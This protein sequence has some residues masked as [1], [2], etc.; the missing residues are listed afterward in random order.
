MADQIARGLVETVGNHSQELEKV[1]ENLA[2][3]AK[4]QKEAIYVIELETWG[5]NGT[6]L[7]N[8]DGLRNAIEWAK[9]NGYNR[10]VVPSKEY[11]YYTITPGS[12]LKAGQAEPTLTIPSFMTIDLNGNTIKIETNSQTT[13]SIIEF[14]KGAKHSVIMNGILEGD[15]E[16]HVYAIKSGTH[17]FGHGVVYR[18]SNFCKL[19]NLEIKN[20]TGDGVYFGSFRTF[21]W[22]DKLTSSNFELG[23]FDETGVKIDSSTTIR[24]INKVLLDDA[25]WENINYLCPEI[26]FEGNYTSENN[27]CDIFMYDSSGVLIKSHIKGMMMDF[28]EKPSNCKYIDMVIYTINI[29]FTNNIFI[30]PLLPTMNCVIENCNIHHNRRQ[31]ITISGVQNCYIKNCRIHNIKGTAPQSGIDVE[32]NRW[33]IKNVIVDN[34]RFYN[35]ASNNIIFYEGSDI[36]L[37]N[38]ILY[39]T[40]SGLVCNIVYGQR[41]IIKNNIFY[42]GNTNFN[43]RRLVYGGLGGQSIVDSNNFVNCK[44]TVNEY[45]V[46]SNNVCQDCTFICSKATFTNCSIHYSD[47]YNNATG[48]F[49]GDN[50]TLRNCIVKSFNTTNNTTTVIN[51]KSCTI[52]NSTIEN[53]HRIKVINGKIVNSKF[54]GINGYEFAYGTSYTN[55]KKLV[56]KDN[57]FNIQGSLTFFGG[58]DIY[59]NQNTFQQDSVVPATNVSGAI[60]ISPSDN[61]NIFKENIIN[62]ND[63][64]Y[65]SRINIRKYSTWST[66][67]YY[68]LFE[69]NSSVG[70]NTRAF[71]S[72][73][74]TLPKSIILK[75]NFLNG[76]LV[77]KT[78]DIDVENNTVLSTQ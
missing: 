55:S 69:N 18:G 34:C 23:A 39:S 3:N 74:S 51:N 24:T 63:D 25:G 32:D 31:G 22:S 15:K 1:N 54:I 29:A 44:I 38:S 60:V 72:V 33:S 73:S 78:R 75:D 59:A 61:I 53:F 20:C 47:I 28:Y 11:G 26:Y 57:L 62:L 46:F 30:R 52:E 21:A 9:T 70:S 40:E 66:F 6:P 58:C 56:L 36:K 2:E 35:N 7:K 77:S 37:L 67:N 50:F 16:T 68:V 17:E 49:I 43:P 71:A 27:Y 41:S 45:I 14:E 76:S 8:R 12:E 48:I 4:K 5:I 19:K 64:I 10:V 65:T 13:Y 42:N